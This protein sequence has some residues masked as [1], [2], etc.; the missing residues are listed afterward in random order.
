MVFKQGL[1]FHASPQPHP[2]RFLPS[3]VSGWVVC[4]PLLAQPRGG[5][6]QKAAPR[7]AGGC[8]ATW[9]APP[10]VRGPPPTSLPRAPATAPSSPWP[11]PSAP[12]APRRPPSTPTRGNPI[13]VFICPTEPGKHPAATPHLDSGSRLPLHELSSL[14]GC[15]RCGALDRFLARPA[16]IFSRHILNFGES[17]RKEKKKKQTGGEKKQKTLPLDPFDK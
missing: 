6:E 2:G 16:E 3:P 5:A 14:L 12:P 10:G 11:P 13:S 1:D 15:W 7:R 9:A 4:A 17:L 8:S